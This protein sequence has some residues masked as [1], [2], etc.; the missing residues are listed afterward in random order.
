MYHPRRPLG[1][2]TTIKTATWRTRATSQRMSPVTMLTMSVRQMVAG[3]KTPGAAV[4]TVS[5]GRLV[6]QIGRTEK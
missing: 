4:R 2:E 1:D 6:R 5:V 3:M